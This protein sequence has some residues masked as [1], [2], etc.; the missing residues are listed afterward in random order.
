MFLW[1]IPYR[2]YFY[3]TF[4]ILFI[5]IEVIRSPFLSAGQPLL[6]LL[7]FVHSSH[8]RI[9]ISSSLLVDCRSYQIY[10]KP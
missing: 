1:K 4:S 2:F 8:L 9:S 5:L 6:L 3:E 7:I 10:K